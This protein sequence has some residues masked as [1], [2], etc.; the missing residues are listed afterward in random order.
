MLP[1]WDLITI[2]VVLWSGIFLERFLFH[3]LGEDKIAPGG[4]DVCVAKKV[5]DSADGAPAL[6]GLKGTGVAEGMRGNLGVS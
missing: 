5:L 2:G 3:L 1:F 6:R 4:I